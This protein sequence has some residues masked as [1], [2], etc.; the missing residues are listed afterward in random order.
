VRPAHSRRTFPGRRRCSVWPW[1][2]SMHFQRIDALV[3][4]AAIQVNKTVEDT[5]R[6]RVGPGNCRQ[7]G[8]RLLCSKFFM[9]CFGRR[10]MHRQHVLCHGF[11]VETA[12]CRLLRTKAGIDRHADQGGWRLITVRTG[13]R[14][15][16]I[17][18]GYSID[19][20]LAE[21]YFQVQ[22]DPA[23][24][25]LAAGKL[26]ALWRIGRPEEVG[27]VAVFLASD[28]CILHD[29]IG[30]GRRWGASVRDCR[31]SA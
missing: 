26:H 20:G 6:R 25:R 10:R 7:P 28:E 17:C 31:R 30:V 21:S 12:V 8:R 27:R 1:T 22:P 11:F 4:N 13:I 15:N 24:A 18:P 19:A 16:C 9:R 5:T 14:I 23:A 29:G 2:R 3:N